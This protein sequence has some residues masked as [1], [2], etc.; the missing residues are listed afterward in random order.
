MKLSFRIQVRYRID[1]KNK[2]MSYCGAIAGL[3]FFLM[4][5]YYFGL[6]NMS[7]YTWDRILFSVLLPM[8]VLVAFGVMTRGTQL[9]VTPIYGI[10]G[11]LF[12]V[13][14]I[15]RTIFY[16][17]V[18]YSIL[19]MIWYVVTALICLATTFGYLSITTY[20]MIAFC[21]SATVRLI[22]DLFAYV[23]RLKL[24]DFLSDA[25]A[26]CGLFAFALFSLCLKGVP[27]KRNHRRLENDN[28]N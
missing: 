23:F 20:M 21:A 17:N 2:W 25:V 9:A 6:Q 26:V 3:G 10:L 14:M 27:I 16:G 19:A 7:D 18:V 28:V 4:M 12:C 11:A 1:F 15:Y 24:L 13:S 8:F 22:I 5:I